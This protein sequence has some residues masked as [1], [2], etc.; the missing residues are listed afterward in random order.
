MNKTKKKP[1]K[2]SSSI[3]KLVKIEWLDHYTANGWSNITSI[4]PVK[5]TTVGFVHSETPTMILVGQQSDALG[6][7]G[8]FSGIIKKCIVSR[9]LLK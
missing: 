2:K 4:D 7:K 9:K 3:G 1:V 5:V 6:N 8:N